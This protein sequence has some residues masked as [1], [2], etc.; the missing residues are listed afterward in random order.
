MAPLRVAIIGGGPGGLMTAYRLEKRTPSVFDVSLF[1][2]SPR[3]GGKILSPR[4]SVADVPYEAGAAELYDYSHLGPDPL[5]ELVAELG[6]TTFPMWGE[7]V[8]LS[9]RLL[10]SASGIRESLGDVATHSLSGFDNQARAEISPAEY[11]E[12]DWRADDADPMTR[13]T[14]ESVLDK[15][16]DDAARRYLEVAVHSDLATEPDLTSGAYGLQ[17]WLMNHREYMRLYGIDGGME[18]L[19]RELARRLT[20]TAVRLSQPVTS[21]ERLGSGRYLVWSRRGNSVSK[22]EFDLVVVALPNNWL[23]F[24]NWRGDGLATAMRKHASRFR[25]PAHYLRVTLLYDRPFWRDRVQD[26]YFMNDAFGGCCL[27]DEG[28]RNGDGIH[29]VLG[30][31]IAGEA[32]LTLANLD[33]ARLIEQARRSLPPMLGELE[34]QFLEGKVH[35]WLGAVSGLPGGRPIQEP[36]ARHVPDPVA[37]PWLFVVGDYLFDATLNGVLDSAD[38]VVEMLMEEAADHA[39]TTAL[40][41]S[42]GVPHPAKAEGPAIQP[43]RHVAGGDQPAPRSNVP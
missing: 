42:A 11:Y 27:Y 13:V 10:T 1:E 36:D 7:G 3:L 39:A 9:D 14:F 22:E 43:E 37:N 17:N 33:D 40:V 41:E 15:I 23:S 29:G 2:A 25:Q 16:G 31:L 24:I 30:L 5:R 4:F 34:A 8:I 28:L 35:R 21:V 38:T 32:A 6:L 19:T 12:S 20:A 26:S 18:R